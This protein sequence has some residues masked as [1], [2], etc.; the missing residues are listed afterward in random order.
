[1]SRALRGFVVNEF[2]SGKYDEIP[3]GSNLTVGEQRLVL[4]GF[5]RDDEPYSGEWAW[6]GVLFMIG[7]SVYSIILSVVFLNNIRYVTGQSLL[8][9]AGDDDI[10]EISEE[11][12]VSIP[13]KRVNLTFKDIRYT[14]QSSITKE[15][16]E[17]LKG[18][19]GVI[20]SGKMTA[21]MGSS[22]AGVCRFGK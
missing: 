8:T 21:L 10:G 16:L 17:L 13:F 7:T 11:D 15:T 12:K 14:V 19:D 3:T 6:W 22:G 5:K 1:M 9:D 18:V 20:E 4:F 2:Q